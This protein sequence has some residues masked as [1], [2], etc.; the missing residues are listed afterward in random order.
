MDKYYIAEIEEKNN[1]TAFNKARNDIEKVFCS[2]KFKKIDSYVKIKNS[3]IPNLKFLKEVIENMKN[4]KNGS[5]LFFQY[6]YYEKHRQMYTMINWIKNRKDISTVAIIHDLDS[7]RFKEINEQKRALRK[8]IKILNKFNYIIS[9]NKK[10]T[11][12][13]VDNG[14][15]SEIVNIDIFDYLLDDKINICNIRKTDIVFAGN[16]SKEKS[17][18]I[19]N[20][21]KDD[22]LKNSMNLYG[23]N[24]QISKTN[25]IKYN[26]VYAP[27]KLIERLEGKFGLIWDGESIDTC[28]GM[29][30][31]YTKYNNPHKTSMYIVSEL[32]IICWNE[33]A[34]SEFVKDNNIGIC[35]NSLD[36]INK[37]LNSITDQQYKIMLD[38][39]I[40]LKSKVSTGYYTNRALSKIQSLI[41]T[42]NN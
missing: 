38:N 3:K 30:G 26:G 1:F 35:I 5:I 33:M 34:I 40:N 27:E 31:Q 39:I 17:G 9:H 28:S 7:L 12:V 29:F 2:N 21:I 41:I 20:L 25:N 23:P 36:E 42:N 19:Y 6:P 15:T 8:E 37:I 16:L 22:V 32:P 18:F 10:M 13:L 24:F 11:K 14:L 4:I